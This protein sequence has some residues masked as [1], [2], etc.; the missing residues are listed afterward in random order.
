M[1]QNGVVIAL[2]AEI[3]GVADKLGRIAEGYTADAILFHIDSY[4]E[5]I[6][7]DLK[8]TRYLYVCKGQ[9]Q[10]PLLDGLGALCVGVRG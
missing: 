10:K 2:S 9:S 8:E 6:Y 4:K 7:S 5:L 3:L 1:I